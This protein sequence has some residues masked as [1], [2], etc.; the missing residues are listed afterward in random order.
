MIDGCSVFGTLDRSKALG[1]NEVSGGAKF[2]HLHDDIT[3]VNLRNATSRPDKEFHQQYIDFVD[4][5]FCYRPHTSI[6]LVSF[7]GMLLINYLAGVI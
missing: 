1:H 6:Q 7:W 5:M 4:V 3:G 2:I